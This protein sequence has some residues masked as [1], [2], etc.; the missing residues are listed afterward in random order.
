MKYV[1]ASLLS[2][3]LLAGCATASFSALKEADR[4]TV[5]DVVEYPGPA[6]DKT[7]NE[8]DGGAC[9]AM[10]DMIVDYG[11]MRDQARAARGEI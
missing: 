2:L 4:L 6:L 8:L 10:A 9:P 3:T 7:S 1:I 5:P 11:V